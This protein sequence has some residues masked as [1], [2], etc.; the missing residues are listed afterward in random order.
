MRFDGRDYVIYGVQLGAHGSRTP[1]GEGFAFREL[2]PDAESG[3][4]SA[5]LR[6]AL[7]AASL[8][9]LAWLAWLRW[10]YG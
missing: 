1:A 6:W 4:A 5:W 9:A 7:A 10:R 8:A 3:L 2:A